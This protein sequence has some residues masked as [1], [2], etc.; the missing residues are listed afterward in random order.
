VSKIVVL[1]R[2]EEEEE[3]EEEEIER[4]T[5]KQTATRDLKR[6]DQNYKNQSTNLDSHDTREVLRG[7][8]ISRPGQDLNTS[9]G[10]SHMQILSNVYSVIVFKVEVSDLV[11]P[12]DRQTDPSRPRNGHA[13][14]LNRKGKIPKSTVQHDK[15]KLR[16]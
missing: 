15:V 14:M 3:E 8:S 4:M 5:T 16:R 13:W 7:S 1:E 11:H 2:K 9:G 6:S 10:S 12:M